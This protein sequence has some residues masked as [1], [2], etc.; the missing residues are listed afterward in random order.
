MC[1]LTDAE[2]FELEE[3][4][5][6]K[7]LLPSV[8]KERHSETELHCTACRPDSFCPEHWR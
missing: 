5:E 6:E 8:M 3:E 1:V 7:L 2:C 4:E